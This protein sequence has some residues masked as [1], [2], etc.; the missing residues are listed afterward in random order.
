MDRKLVAYVLVMLLVGTAGAYSLAN[1]TPVSGT[2]PIET[3][4]GVTVY[5][6]DNGGEMNLQDP[7][8]D[9]ETVNITTSNGNATVSGSGTAN[10]TLRSVTGDTN[11]T[12]ADVDQT[13]VTVNPEDKGGVVVG[14]GLE[15]FNYSGAPTLDDGNVDFG[16]GGSGP[17]SEVTLRTAPANTQIGAIDAQS[18][19][20]L[21]VAT[22]DGNGNV[23][24][25]LSN[26]Q[27]NVELVSG[28]TAAPTVS[29]ET[30]TGNLT[31]A[32]SQLSI[33]A[34]DTDM[35]DDNITATFELDGN[36]VGTDS[37]SDNGTLSTSISNPVGGDHTVT[38]TVEDAYGNSRTVSYDFAVPDTLT[39]R[40]ETNASQTLANVN[41]TV[42]FRGNNEVVTRQSDANG[43]I[44]LEGYP[45]GQPYFVQLEDDGYENR[46]VA[47]TNIYEQQTAYLLN[48]SINNVDVRFEIND[49]TGRYPSDETIII[50]ERPITR[51]FD[52]DGSDET[53]L[54]RV[55]SDEVGVSGSLFSLENNVRYRLAV[56]NENGDIRQLGSYETIQN[57]T[58]VLDIGTLGV[59]IGGDDTYG[60]STSFE[61]E[62]NPTINYEFSDPDNQTTDL[63]VTIYERGN[64]NNTTFSKT[65]PGPLGNVSVS[66]VLSTQNDSKTWVVEWQ[67]E[68]NGEQISGST[69]VGPRVT[70]GVPL[71]PLLK[72][73]LAV[74]ML[75]LVGG[76]FGGVKSE[77][78]AVVMSLLAGGL[79]MVEW[80]PPA[81]GAGAIVLALA[82][83]ILG[84]I[85]RTPEVV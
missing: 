62:T 65:Y 57:E 85:N 9:S 83:A 79:W 61:N 63:N 30:P 78:G 47:I 7:W 59:D 67:A 70:F 55:A 22:S 23:T 51:D 16:Y 81:I 32:P 26:S 74:G 68:R 31:S 56:R 18:G 11:I 13:N 43:N 10:I 21:D 17:E 12:N 38:V 76:L 40:N 2:I 36:Q 15:Q 45:V 52:G 1:S 49:R 71:S 37:R 53:R 69:I 25:T 28:G 5:V 77:L 19:E 60:V 42:T 24:F 33:D 4:S 39:I 54:S 34:S 27:H 66:H 3:Q 75:I 44:S 46:Q 58:V 72:H 84:R 29:N 50:I 41:A 6:A 82:I 64:P 73:S 20:V 14:G 80:L 8:V 48:S 35:P